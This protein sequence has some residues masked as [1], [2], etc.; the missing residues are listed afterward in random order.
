MTNNQTLLSKS[1]N[2]F[3]TGRVSVFTPVK[4][5]VT[6]EASMAIPLFIFAVVCLLYLMAI[7]AVQTAVRAGLQ[8]AG[9]VMSTKAI[10]VPLVVSSD[11]ETEV[12]HAI[13]A[14]RMDRSVIVGGSSGIHCEGSYLSPLTGIG[15]VRAEYQIR[16][17]VP[18]FR[19]NLITLEEELRIKAWTGYE[20]EG[21]SLE[22]EE[23]VYLTET[24]VV[25][26]KDYHCNYL[27]LSIRMVSME[28]VGDLRN[29][30]GEIYHPC[31]QCAGSVASSVY[32]TDYGNRY[33]GSLT[34]SGLKRTVYAVPKSEVL[35]KGAC[36]KC[37]K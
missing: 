31:G 15:K 11:V 34:C 6:V 3:Y 10:E 33:H 20:K 37:G 26:H 7:M 2:Y 35:G 12:I 21:V 25:Y 29:P 1:K 9:K 28:Q 19:I 22:Q 30:S 23:I 17:P 14:E 18:F 27:E 32:I 13:G 5:S 24:G 4:A 16:I 8:S 36:S